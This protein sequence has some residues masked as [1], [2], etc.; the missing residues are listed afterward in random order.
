V[1]LGG[2]VL[3]IAWLSGPVRLLN[4]VR[5]DARV[6]EGTKMGSPLCMGHEAAHHIEAILLRQQTKTAAWRCGVFAVFATSAVV[7]RGRIH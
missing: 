6:N 4:C 3:Y 1:S 7:D 5:P 2:G